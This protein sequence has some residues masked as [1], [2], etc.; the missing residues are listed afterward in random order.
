VNQS[1]IY[2]K[3]TTAFHEVFDDD[4]IVLSANTSAGDVIGWDSFAHIRLML[5]IERAF[6]AYLSP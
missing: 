2:A 5:T 3:L 4:G 1:D 6:S